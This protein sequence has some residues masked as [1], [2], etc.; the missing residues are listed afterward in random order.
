M[1][2]QRQNTLW[3]SRSDISGSGQVMILLFI[4]LYIF[5][6]SSLLADENLWST[7]GPSGGSVKTIAI[8]P[9]DNQIVYLGTISNGIYRS[10]NAGD[11]WQHLDLG[12]L[13]NTQRVIAIHPFAPETLYAATARGLFKSSDGGID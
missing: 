10:D 1:L 8:H 13:D 3:L 11:S 7:N 2:G 9:F 5:L 6:A 12:I 4:I